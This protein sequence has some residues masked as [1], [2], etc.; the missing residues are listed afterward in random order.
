[1]EPA[2]GGLGIVDLPDAALAKVGEF[3]PKT[4]AG[5][6]AVALTAPPSSWRRGGWEGRPSAAVA[7]VLSSVSS[8]VEGGHGWEILDFTDV[9]REPKARHRIDEEED[10]ESVILKRGYILQENYKNLQTN[11]K[12]TICGGDVVEET[13]ANKLNDKDIG[14]L[15]ACIDAVHKVQRIKLAGCVGITGKCLEPLRG[16]SVLEQLDLCLAGEHEDPCIEPVPKTSVSKVIPIL[17]SIIRKEGNVLKQ[18]QLP[19]K[20]IATGYQEPPHRYTHDGLAN[21]LSEYS[22]YSAQISDRRQIDPTIRRVSPTVR[23][24]GLLGRHK[25]TCY[26][27][28]ES[29]CVS[30]GNFGG[31][32]TCHRH[33]CGTC[34]P[35]DEGIHCNGPWCGGLCCKKCVTTKKCKDCGQDHVF[36]DECLHETY[37]VCQKC[38]KTEKRVCFDCTLFEECVECKKMLCSKCCCSC[39]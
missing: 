16:S 36:C 5:L 14:A 9:H 1:M 8:G 11:T 28:L 20:W 31:C 30:R 19:I 18:L 12:A 35:E 37:R 6:L 33:Y 26:K 17:Q 13:L 22:E 29:I 32:E 7:A 4:S 15:L 25:F 10:D 38:K 27:C 3:V 39:D 23:Y 21:F 2:G 24:D 34:H